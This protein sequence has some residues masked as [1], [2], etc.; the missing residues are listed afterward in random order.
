METRNDTRWSAG[1][2][3]RW[4]P[5][6]EKLEQ[7]NAAMIAADDMGPTGVAEHMLS[8]FARIQANAVKSPVHRFR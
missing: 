4:P 5:T 6:R 3:R 8:E 7:Y 1:A 2:S